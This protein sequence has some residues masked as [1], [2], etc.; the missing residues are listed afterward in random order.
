MLIPCLVKIKNLEQLVLIYFIKHD[1][2]NNHFIQK[3]WYI[4]V[5][6]P[7]AFPELTH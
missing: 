4:K 6:I 3:T 2:T 1:I 7:S 5:L